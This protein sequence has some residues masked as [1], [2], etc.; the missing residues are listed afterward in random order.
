MSSSHD[1][2][3]LA[4]VQVA[5]IQT[6]HNPRLWSP[7][8][9]QPV[10]E[11]S[12]TLPSLPTTVNEKHGDNIMSASH[13]AYDPGQNDCWDSHAAFDPL[14]TLWPTSDRQPLF[15]IVNQ[16]TTLWHHFLD[17]SIP[18]SSPACSSHMMH[19]HHSSVSNDSNVTEPF[20]PCH[21]V[22][23]QSFSP[24][25][26]HCSPHPTSIGF[27]GTDPHS[28]LS[29]HCVPHRNFTGS[30]HRRCAARAIEY[31]GLWIDE[32][33]LLKGLMAPDGKVNVH[34]CR[35]EEDR[36]PCHLWIR[37][38]KSCINTHIQKWHGGKPGGDKSQFGCRWSTCGKTM[39]KESIARHIVSIHL[40]EMWECQGCGKD[41]A[42]NDAYGRHAVRSNSEACRASGALITYSADTREINARAA[43]D[44][45]G[46][47]RYAGA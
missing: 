26:S 18:H 31:D 39:L 37:G 28:H 34:Q 45:G 20:I 16:E 6:P 15:P 38:D 9:V 44:G 24:T 29:F 13:S 22:S 8:G 11:V 12:S 41:I 43:L 3:T 21:S 40:G 46:R 36:S 19:P 2:G 17:Q 1:P 5:R 25:S 30:P 35:W 33:E 10:V 32:E 23:Y 42:R 14:R 47:L 7:S 27:H 4:S